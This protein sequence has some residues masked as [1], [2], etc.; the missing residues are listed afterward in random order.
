MPR[1]VILWQPTESCLIIK[2]NG[3]GSPRTPPLPR[4][5]TDDADAAEQSRMWSRCTDWRRPCR[6]CAVW[7]T[8]TGSPPWL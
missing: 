4:I 7:R 3:H 1:G 5:P 8:N 6:P 2:R